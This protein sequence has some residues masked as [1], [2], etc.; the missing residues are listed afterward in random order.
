M[1]KN[2][3]KNQPRSLFV[4]DAEDKLGGKMKAKKFVISLV[5]VLV[6]I[7]AIYGAY[8]AYCE[9]TV[10][11]GPCLRAVVDCEQW[12]DPC[13]VEEELKCIAKVCQFCDSIKGMIDPNLSNV[14]QD[15]NDPNLNVAFQDVNDLSLKIIEQLKAIKPCEAQD[16]ALLK[17]KHT[18][19]MRNDGSESIENLGII[20]EKAKYVEYKKEGEKKTKIRGEKQIITLGN[21]L[22]GA[23]IEMDVWATC[24][25]SKRPEFKIRHSR[26]PQ[27]IYIRTPIGKIAGLVD[28]YKKTSYCL[29]LLPSVFI[30][31]AA[32]HNYFI[33][34]RA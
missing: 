7:A 24:E 19:K 32:C 8:L 31:I 1:G 11:R 22:P 14:V 26:R 16:V 21:L 9:L 25:V 34:K 33:R 13:D 27:D 18:I 15:V 5:S 2:N 28:E 10:N 30:I 29:M 17:S 12:K 3:Q 20:F 23:T 6:S 4:D